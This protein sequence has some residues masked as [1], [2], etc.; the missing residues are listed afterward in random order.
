MILWLDHRTFGNGFGLKS[1]YFDDN[2]YWLSGELYTWT[3]WFG[4]QLQSFQWRHP[5]A[6][7]RRMLFGYKFYP[8]NSERRFMRLW[9][10]VLPIPRVRVSWARV[11]LPE[12]TDA[13]N[14]ELRLMLQKIARL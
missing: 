2:F 9:S 8:F 7:E 10:I 1:P 4:A 3:G 6:G 13:A 12:G 14:E 11:D 5:K